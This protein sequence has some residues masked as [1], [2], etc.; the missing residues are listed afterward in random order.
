M[1]KN[2]GRVRTARNQVNLLPLE[3]P[4]DE[5]WAALLAHV[6]LKLKSIWIDTYL[7]ELI[8]DEIRKSKI[9]K[10]LMSPPIEEFARIKN[11]RMIEFILQEHLYNFQQFNTEL[12]TETRNFR[13]DL[14]R[15]KTNVLKYLLPYTFE[16]LPLHDGRMDFRI[17]ILR[18]IMEKLPLDCN[19]T[20]DKTGNNPIHITVSRSDIINLKFFINRKEGLTALNAENKKGQSPLYL[21]VVNGFIEIVKIV[22]ENL[23]EQQ[24][25]NSKCGI[26]L[27]GANV[28][29]IAAKHG[30]L[31]ILKFLATKV[32]N[33]NVSDD[34]GYTPIHLAAKTG[35][36]KVVKFMA[37]YTSEP[38][39]NNYGM[40]PVS[41]AKSHEHDDIVQ[42][43]ERM[44]QKRKS[45]E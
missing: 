37:S 1:L 23:N 5:M 44:S 8:L 25:M 6:H 35:H 12:N 11:V 15:G 17:R 9:S 29:H 28:F 39:A 7:Q 33:T 16:K 4:D 19:L 20:V 45:K 30:H 32:S 41:L 31:E 10:R 14:A 26:H 21:A 18:D 27:K 24:I 38:A 13:R 3:R 42:F 40:T 2:S 22:A 36:L 34:F 43:L